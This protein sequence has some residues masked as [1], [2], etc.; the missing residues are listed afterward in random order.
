LL[1]GSEGGPLGG[2]LLGGSEGGPLG[3]GFSVEAASS[4]VS[5]ASSSDD[6]WGGGVGDSTTSI[7]LSPKVEV[8]KSDISISFSSSLSF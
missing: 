6:V 7:S 8:N 5:G 2:P 1:G 3:G 4:S